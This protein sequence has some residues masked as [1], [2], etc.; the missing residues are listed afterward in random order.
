MK[1]PPYF[2]PALHRTKVR[3]RSRK[4]L[5]HSQNIWTLKNNVNNKIWNST[6]IMTSNFGFLLLHRRASKVTFTSCSTLCPRVTSPLW[7]CHTSFC[8][9]MAIGSLTFFTD[10]RPSFIYI[11][12]ISHILEHEFLCLVCS[13]SYGGKKI[14]CFWATFEG[15]FFSTFC[16]QK[17]L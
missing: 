2:W 8:P 11:W 12:S 9:F 7:G 10:V 3:W 17:T 16:G 15:G 14:K 13:G 6:I 1:S 4:I 5:W